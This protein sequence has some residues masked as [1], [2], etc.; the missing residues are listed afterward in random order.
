MCERVQSNCMPPCALAQQT[1]RYNCNH[2][3]P[4]HHPPPFPLDVLT[5]CSIPPPP[6][7]PTQH[8]QSILLPRRCTAVRLP[9][10]HALYRR[11]FNAVRAWAS[12]DSQSCYCTSLFQPPP[13]PPTAVPAVRTRPPQSHYTH[14]WW[15]R[16]E[17]HSRVR[18]TALPTHTMCHHPIRGPSTKHA[19]AQDILTTVSTA[20]T[21]Q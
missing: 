11:T 10:N 9:P 3:Q 21:H 1:L 19:C 17:G 15:W 18:H 16:R 20:D 13:P 6:N 5:S 12:H 7:A 8:R 2:R 14:G 4:P